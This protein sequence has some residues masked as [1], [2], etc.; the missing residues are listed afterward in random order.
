MKRQMKIAAVVSA[1]ALLAIGA[2]FTSMAAAKTGNWTQE[3][4]TWYCYDKNGDVIENEFCLDG[5]KEFYV[6]DDGAVV[7]SS[8]VEHDGHMYYI[9]SDGSKASGV[10][11]QLTPFEDEDADEE[12]YYFSA[13]GKRVESDYVTY[14]GARYYFD[15]EGKNLTGWV[16]KASYTQADENTAIADLVYCGEDG[17]R[18]TKDWVEVYA[19]GVNVE[20]DDLDEHDP[21][22]YYLKS[23]GTPQTGKAAN[24]EGE[25]YFFNNKGQMLD[26]WI[27][28]TTADAYE[29]VDGSAYKDGQEIGAMGKNVYFA[30][31]ED[32]HVKKNKWIYEWSNTN[33]YKADPDVSKNWY[34]I[35]KDGK[36]YIPTTASSSSADLIDFVDGEA[37]TP[38][39]VD[40]A[41][42]MIAKRT[43]N[44]EMYAFDANGKM[45]SGFIMFNDDDMY[46]F[47]KSTDGARKTG[48]QTIADENGESFK[49]YFGTEDDKG[50]NKGVGISGAKNGKLYNDGLLVKAEDYKYQV[51]TVDGLKFIVNKNGSI[52]TSKDTYE[53]D[54]VVIT[55]A[56]EAT[57]VETPGITKGSVTGLK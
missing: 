48:A 21:Y 2:S 28:E 52:Q 15:A 11:K 7:Y 5:N 16:D 55:N 50:Y 27:V 44:N 3:D 35:E 42:V 18:V 6:G 30:C 57:F 33:M 46:Y 4:G 20:E 9:Q 1:T 43:I 17:A 40:T 14:N 47:G 10:W 32:G 51:V 49:F 25:T 13:S 26:G 53:D 54:G 56:K 34:W 41:D 29:A 45:K 37:R 23:L 12:W 24:I 22:W 36:V 19:P 38:F 8:W 39:E 31:T